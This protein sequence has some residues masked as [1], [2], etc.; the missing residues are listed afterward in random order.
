MIT[1]FTED[2]AFDSGRRRILGKALEVPIEC[3]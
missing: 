2:L 1:V 3:R